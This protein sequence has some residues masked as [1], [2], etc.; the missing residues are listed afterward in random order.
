MANRSLK[1]LGEDMKKSRWI[2]RFSPRAD[3][4]VIRV[5]VGRKF[6]QTLNS[7]SLEQLDDNTVLLL[8]VMGYKCTTRPSKLILADFKI[9]SVGVEIM[10]WQRKLNEALGLE[11]GMNLL[12]PLNRR[13]QLDKMLEED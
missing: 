13:A 8:R 2:Q 12:I 10:K 11:G 5:S 7:M 4:Q 6:I 9:R 1:R 3:Y